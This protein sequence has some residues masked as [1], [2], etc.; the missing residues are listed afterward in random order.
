LPE[1][2]DSAA[3]DLT[4][5]AGYACIAAAMG[6]GE[7]MRPKL[8]RIFFARLSREE[9]QIVVGAIEQSFE[10]KVGR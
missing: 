5:S 9:L 2:A 4:S 3:F 8:A 10:R 6:F 7:N 1:A